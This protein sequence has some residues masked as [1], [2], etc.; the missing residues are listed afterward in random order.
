MYFLQF[1]LNLY[2]TNIKMYKTNANFYNTVGKSHITI[3]YNE[4]RKFKT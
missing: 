1:K 2:S 3:I 4:N